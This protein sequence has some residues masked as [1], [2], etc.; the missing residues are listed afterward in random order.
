MTDQKIDAPTGKTTAKMDRL[1]IANDSLA[2]MDIALGKAAVIEHY[3]GAGVVLAEVIYDTIAE[4]PP[5]VLPPQ[6][7]AVLIEGLKAAERNGLERLVAPYRDKVAAIDHQVL[8]NKNATDG[9]IEHLAGF[10]M[11]IKPICQHTQLVDRLNAPLDWSLMRSADCPVLISKQDWTDTSVLVAAVDAADTDH[12]ALNQQILT[13]ANDLAN[14]LGARLHVVC[15][16]PSLGQQRGELQVAMDYDGIKADM[17]DSRD[18]L[19]HDL[20]GELNIE[21]AEL[22]LLEGK[23]GT[24]IPAKANELGATITVLGTAARRGL[25]QLIIGNTA[26]RIIEALNGDVVTVREL[27]S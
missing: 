6:Q 24:V 5:E 25:S 11:L 12:L 18:H 7:Q 4:E 3:T 20:I 10:D 23:P 8:W 1:L 22:H 19:I 21:V 15:A 16:Y 2:G 27:T 26:E 14:V 13:V 9:I 17:R